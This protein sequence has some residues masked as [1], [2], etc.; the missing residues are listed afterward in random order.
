ME[1]MQ[2]AAVELLFGLSS[3]VPYFVLISSP[4]PRFMDRYLYQWLSSLLRIGIYFVLDKQFP[5]PGSDVSAGADVSW[6]MY[7]F[8]IVSEVVLNALFSVSAAGITLQQFFAPK[9]AN[10]WSKRASTLQW[11]L[12]LFLMPLS[13][14]IFFRVFLFSRW[15]ALLGF[16]P[17]LALQSAWFLA[18]HSPFMWV[19]AFRSISYAMTFYFSGGS[20]VA[21]WICHVTNNILAMQFDTRQ[22]L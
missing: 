5:V 9:K 22:A 21:S 17:A 4:A 6:M 7:C 1:L 2:A 3:D 14:E 13:E 10:S 15:Q 8:V 20:L 12:L 11:T 19:R 16:L 18:N